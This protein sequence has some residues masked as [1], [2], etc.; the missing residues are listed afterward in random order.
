MKEREKFNSRLGF[1]LISAGCAIGLGNVYRFPLITGANGGGWF[2]L[3]Y[4]AFL[5]L[6]GIPTMTCELA[7]GRASQRSIVTSFHLL[8]KPNQ[9]WGFMRYVGLIGNYLLMMFYT[10]ISG[11]MMIYFVK[12]L[13]GS[14]CN[15]PNDELINVFLDIIA[16]PYLLI[17]TTAIVIVLGFGVCALGLKNGVEKITKV[18]MLALFALMIGLVIYSLT[19]SGA[20]E[21]LKFYLVPNAESMSN[22]GFL[23]VVSSAMGQ[24]FFTLSVGIG[25]IAIFGSYIT[26]ERSL[27]GETITIV[28]LDTAI[29]LMAGL[30]IFPA[31]FT[32]GTNPSTNAT[33]AVFLF[34]TLAN[35]F[36]NMGAVS[37]RIIGTLFFLFMIFASLSTVIAVFENI[38]SFW[39]ELSDIKK[40]KSDN[41]SFIDSNGKSLDRWKICLINVCLLLILS[42]P[43]IFSGNILSDISIKTSTKTRDIIDIEDFIVSN[44]LLP[45]G[46]LMYVIFCTHKFGWGWKKYEKEVN[47]GQGIKVPKWL[48]FY[49]KWILPA[50]IVFVFVVSVFGFFKP[51]LFAP[52]LIESACL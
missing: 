3:I 35:I 26:K 8:Q 11:W 23:P 4:I 6:L 36:N 32:Y 24:A 5:I 42:L 19:L 12:Y 15:V 43:A 41:G 33:S 48:R 20:G 27:L 40:T 21:G 30:I 44:C 50:I 47:C 25:S 17:G 13:T 7:V 1:I 46:S 37:G 34:T 51:E 38:V 9:K 14:I 52:E 29:A 2:V 45:L 16:N 39:L 28:S 49:M 31:C 22:V 10:V 18:I